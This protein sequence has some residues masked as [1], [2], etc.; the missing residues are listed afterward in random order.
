MQRLIR[1][2]AL[3]AVVG[4]F[5]V[6]AS[7]AGAKE[8]PA[9]GEDG[10]PGVV[11]HINH[12]AMSDCPSATGPT[13]LSYM[14]AWNGGEWGGQLSAW[15]QNDFGCHNHANNPYLRSFWNRTPYNVRIGGWGVLGP[16]LGLQMPINQPITGDIC[17][18][19]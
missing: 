12:L 5:T 1:L 14:C 2:S 16:G 8:A 7:V 6:S 3:L 18:P 19:A 11:K 13:W 4:V 10:S 17:W 9:A 15:T